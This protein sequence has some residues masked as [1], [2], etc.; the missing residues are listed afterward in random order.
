MANSTS[1]RGRRP[2]TPYGWLGAGAVGVGVWA[3][4]AGGAAVAHAEGPAADSTSSGSVGRD[5]SAAANSGVARRPSRTAASR[6]ARQTPMSSVGVSDS[7]PAGVPAVASRVR[8]DLS[9]VAP[10]AAA[11]WQPGSVLRFVIGNGTADNP[12]AGILLGNGFSYDYPTCSQGGCNGGNGGM[13]GNGGDGFAGGHGG[14]AGWFGSGGKGGA[15]TAVGGTGGRGGSGGLFIGDGGTGGPGGP[16]GGVG[17]DGGSAG[18]LSVLGTGGIGGAG[19]VGVDGGPAGKSGF[20]GSPTGPNAPGLAW[21]ARIALDLFL[22]GGALLGLQSGYVAM[23]AV[24]GNVVDAATA[25]YADIASRTPMELDTRFRIASMTKPITAVAAMILVEEGRLGLDD[26]VAQYIPA[27][28]DLRVATSQTALPDGTIPSVALDAPLTVRDLLKFSSG[29]GGGGN[30]S[31]LERLWAANNLYAGSGSLAQRVDR[32]FTAPLY[33]QPGTRWRYG[34]SADVLARVVEV[35]S[36]EPFGD[37]VTGRI[38]APLGMTSTEFLTAE[39]PRDRLATMYTQDS[40]GHLVAVDRLG[41]DSLDWTPGGSGLVSTA[42]DYMRFALMLWNRGT[43]QDTQILKPE[44]VT[45]MTQ[46]AVQSGVL[47]DSGIEGLGWGL[48]MAVVVDGDATATFDRTGDFWWSGTYGTTFFVSPTT[49]LVGIVLSQNQ[50]GPYS[51]TPYV[52]YLA[53]ALAFLGL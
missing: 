34:W 52:V 17:G 53:Q 40:A 10:T 36:G 37:F 7:H 46:P 22:K 51:P 35:A 15:A 48:G 23:F 13:I 5:V 14:A 27:A 49:G 31:D 6:V 28:A 12:N 45:L 42:G 16:G 33:E 50:S 44:T 26:P 8:R 38:L 24:D 32:I 1:T 30:A 47:V 4:L 2:R 19:G 18:V 11:G 29:I 9:G 3:A 25:G 20:D 39:S 21:P 41:G 43:F